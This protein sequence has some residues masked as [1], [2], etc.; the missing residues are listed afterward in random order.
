[1]FLIGL[2]LVTNR[3]VKTCGVSG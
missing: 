1:M 2:Q 3:S